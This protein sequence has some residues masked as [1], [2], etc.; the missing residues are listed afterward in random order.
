MDKC[1]SSLECNPQLSLK[2]EL[3][4]PLESVY[5]CS[6]D[7]GTFWNGATCAKQLLSGVACTTTSECRQDLGLFCDSKSLKCS[8]PIGNYW[9]GALCRIYDNFKI[10]LKPIHEVTKITIFNN[11]R[12]VNITLFNAKSSIFNSKNL[13]A[14]YI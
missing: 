5:R 4:N 13:R 9:N 14:Y 8:C 6:C 11:A 10:N 7:N 12:K 2:C 1:S 3:K